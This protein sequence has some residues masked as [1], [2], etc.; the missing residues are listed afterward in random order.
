MFVLKEVVFLDK[1]QVSNEYLIISAFILIVI[2]FLFIFSYSNASETV[3]VSSTENAV[4]TLAKAANDVYA[5]GPG[6]QRMV[7]INLP[8]GVVN[9]YVLNN[10]IGYV[11][12]TKDINFDIYKNTEAEIGGELPITEGKHFVIV[13]MLDSGI[14]RIGGGL[15][16][17]PSKFIRVISTG[18]FD[19]STFSVWNNTSKTLT[20]LNATLTG[21]ITDIA[22]FAGGEDSIIIANTINPDETI[23]FS[24]NWT[25]PLFS[26][27]KEYKGYIELYS[28]ENYFDKAL[29][30]VTV[31]HELTDLNVTLFGDSNYSAPKTE[32]YQG[33]TVY[34]KITVSDQ[35]GETMD[36]TDLNITISDPP[37]IGNQSTLTGLAT[38][39]GVY[40]G[41]ESVSCTSETGTWSILGEGREYGA[42]DDTNSYEIDTATE[43]TKFSFS[44]ADAYPSGTRLKDFAYGNVC[45]P[46][47]TIKR[48]RVNVSSGVQVNE[49]ELNDDEVWSG[50]PTS[51]WVDVNW[52]SGTIVTANTIYTSDNEMKFSSAVGSGNTYTIDFEFDDSSVYT[53]VFVK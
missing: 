53:A 38:I 52:P 24:I 29:L 11:M 5:L 31:P 7:E 9:Q 34:Y 26:A 44:Y 17:I 33:Q 27:A 13:Q 6:N 48:M 28:A 42:A 4:N 16:I 46:D 12:Q 41:E 1:G 22:S 32:F 36:I 47:I 20:D 30:Q 8:A 25:V 21:N 10:Q 50:T 45:V 35:T 43:A 40:L 14:V 37:P 23:N 51:D 39:D 2:G 15:I 19:F 49:I 3:A 18:T